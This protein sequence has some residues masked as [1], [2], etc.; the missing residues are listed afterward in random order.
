MKIAPWKTFGLQDKLE[1]HTVE[2]TLWLWH[3]RKSCDR[4]A[5]IARAVKNYEYQCVEITV[6]VRC[7]S[8]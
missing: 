3:K 2:E 5:F 6:F 4:L 8:T 1:C 7:D